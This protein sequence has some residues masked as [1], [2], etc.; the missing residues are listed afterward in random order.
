MIGCP[1]DGC[2]EDFVHAILL[3][4]H[5]RRRHVVAEQAPV[6][7]LCATRDMGGGEAG[8]SG[9]AGD[10]GVFSHR[11]PAVG[12]ADGGP[13]AVG[14]D[15][16]GSPED[17]PRAEDEVGSVGT[18]DGQSSES[19]C[20]EDD[21]SSGGGSDME[22][23]D[24]SSGVDA[25]PAEQEGECGA[26]CGSRTPGSMGG[27][28]EPLDDVDFED[29]ALYELYSLPARHYPGE[30][31][32]GAGDLGS[33]LCGHVLD[34]YNA[35]RI[36]S[37]PVYHPATFA[38]SR[39]HVSAF[40][41]PATRQ[42][43]FHACTSGGAGVSKGEV[44]RLY[45]LCRRVE[46]GTGSTTRPIKDAFKPKTAIKEAVQKEKKRLLQL[47]GWREADAPTFLGS[48]RI[49]FRSGMLEIMKAI[50]S[51]PAIRWERGGG[52][53]SCREGVRYDGTRRNTS[54]DN[55]MHG[56]ASNAETPRV[57]TGC[58]ECT[59]DVHETDGLQLLPMQKDEVL[60][61]CFDGK[62]YEAQRADVIQVLGVGA[63]MLAWALYYDVT[64]VTSSEGKAWSAMCGASVC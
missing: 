60:R 58:S 23:D 18:S 6:E 55:A 12:S 2:L 32:V 43:F 52:A 38:S 39:R 13:G 10:G 1:A 8:C 30:M 61:D 26:N 14:G 35:L 59:P 57:E 50:A 19:G 16:G 15:L 5:L 56:D 44:A 63:L 7:D 25:V 28:V 27:S 22:A 42:F 53:C 9:E 46:D 49:I 33:S 64:V 31:E 17:D 45:R 3:G 54:T 20:S 21:D 51:A 40:R 24:V 47:L 37:N 4:R 34:H 48:Q 29:H 62:T 36:I 41:S 11:L